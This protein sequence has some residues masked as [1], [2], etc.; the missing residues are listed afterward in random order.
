MDKDLHRTKPTMLGPAACMDAPEGYFVKPPCDSCGHQ[1]KHDGNGGIVVMTVRLSDW[2]ANRKVMENTGSV[3]F[4][5]MF[6]GFR[7]GAGYGNMTLR[8]EDE[9]GNRLTEWERDT[10]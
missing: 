4:N 9:D 3:V 8:I 10:Y 5:A 2:N 7:A 6:A 1:T